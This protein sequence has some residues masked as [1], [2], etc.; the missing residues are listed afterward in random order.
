MQLMWLVKAGGSADP[1]LTF[2][3][4]ALAWETP[5]VPAVLWN[6]RREQS[7]RTVSG[8][9]EGTVIILSGQGCA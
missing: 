1:T 8:N 7:Q 5:H 6:S 3:G 9:E 4:A 2:P